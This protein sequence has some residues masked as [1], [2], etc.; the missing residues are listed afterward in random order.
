MSTALAEKRANKVGDNFVTANFIGERH[1]TYA[2]F[3]W[4]ELKE[5]EL[6]ELIDGELMFF[7]APVWDHQQISGELS[8]QIKSYLKGK[9]GKVCA[10]PFDVSLFPKDDGS[11]DTVVMPDLFVVLDMEKVKDK[12]LCKGA[13]DWII[14]ILSP[15]TR[16][17][18][19][20][21]KFNQYLKAGVRE[22]WIVSPDDKT[23]Q[24]HI[25]KDGN[26]N[27]LTS[28]YKSDETIAVS[29]LPGCSISLP[30]VFAD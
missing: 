29:V 15:A 11:D 5:G 18:D 16:S 30:D 28:A 21:V 8:F 7:N 13:P 25:L 24:V 3:P 9:E 1:Y 26:Y 20:V 2:T 6:A 10:A 19:N 27:Y 14:E 17:H 12:R 4:E 23:V 22:Y